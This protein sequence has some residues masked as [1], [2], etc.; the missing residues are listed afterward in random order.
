MIGGPGPGQPSIDGAWRDE[1]SRLETG[2]EPGPLS[3][4]LWGCF[5]GGRDKRGDSEPLGLLSQCV[6]H[7]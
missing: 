1:Y 4:P 6:Q 7:P 2:I 3:P 5:P